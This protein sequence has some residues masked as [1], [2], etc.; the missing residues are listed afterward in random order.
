MDMPS[1]RQLVILLVGCFILG[2]GVALLLTADLGS[3][4]YSTLI[5]GLSIGTGWSWAAVSVAVAVLFLVMAF[6]RGLTPG[7]GTIAQVAIVSAT[8]PVVMGLIHTP[9]TLVGQILMLALA[10]PLLAAGIACYLGS[11]TG[12]GPTEAAALAWDPP[13]PFKWSYSAVQFGGALIGWLTGTTV[14]VATLV[15]I[16]LLGPA[17]TLA[18][19]LL[20]LDVHQHN[21]HEDD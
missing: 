18:G 12:A 21:R 2:L 6:V 20:R 5:T 10:F 17:V 13:I 3:D 8:V 1:L 16:L 7:V 15:V 19:S 9:G 11:H 14:G 4:G